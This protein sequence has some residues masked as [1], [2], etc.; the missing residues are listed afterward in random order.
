MPDRPVTVQTSVRT[1]VLTVRL[2]HERIRELTS[3]PRLR[4]PRNRTKKMHFFPIKFIF[5]FLIFFLKKKKEK[6]IVLIKNDFLDKKN[7]KV[8]LSLINAKV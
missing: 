6:K 2:R 8:I 7:K 1:E 3:K 5:F 4:D